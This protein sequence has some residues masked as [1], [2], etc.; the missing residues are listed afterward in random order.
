MTLAVLQP[1]TQMFFFI[2]FSKLRSNDFSRVT[3]LYSDFSARF[4]ITPTIIR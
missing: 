3:G 2:F 1:F 4:Q